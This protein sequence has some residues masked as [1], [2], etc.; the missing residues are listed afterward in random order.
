MLILKRLLVIN[1]AYHVPKKAWVCITVIPETISFTKKNVTNFSGGWGWEAPDV[2][3]TG[4]CGCSSCFPGVC[5]PMKPAWPHTNGGQEVRA[6][7]TWWFS[8]YSSTCVISKGHRECKQ[9]GFGSELSQKWFSHLFY[10]LLK[11]MATSN[12]GRYF[13]L[14]FFSFKESQWR[15]LKKQEESDRHSIYNTG[16]SVH[17][18][19]R[20]AST[21]L[22]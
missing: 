12:I 4:E 11:M 14:L 22:S 2:G 7:C 1:F 9:K 3:A 20:E 19:C 18:W 16:S 6:P 15:H 5:W 13:F 17:S 8:M 10:L 21:V